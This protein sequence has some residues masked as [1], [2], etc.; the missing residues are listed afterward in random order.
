MRMCA[1]HRQGERP[2]PMDKPMDAKD[3]SATTRPEG[4]PGGRGPMLSGRQGR[5]WRGCA[6]RGED[7]AFAGKPI[8][9]APPRRRRIRV[10]CPPPI[11]AQHLP[12][13]ARARTSPPPV[14]ASSPAAPL[15]PRRCSACPV[16]HVPPGARRTHLRRSDAA[17]VQPK[18]KCGRDTPDGDPHVTFFSRQFFFFTRSLQP[19]A[20]V[21]ILIVRASSFPR[22][23]PL[24][25]APPPLSPSHSTGCALHPG[26][27]W[28]D[29]D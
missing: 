1:R 21:S 6:R 5:S 12:P 28:R 24:W 3:R 8:L 20:P 29:F 23:R 18:T 10:A 22:R 19:T 26:G 2:P 11:R 7:D 16:P 4:D 17:A 25:S 15:A 14:L 13:W 27:C 9:D